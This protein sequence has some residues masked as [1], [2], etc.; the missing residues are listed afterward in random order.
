[1]SRFYSL[2][3]QL[4]PLTEW[5]P[6]LCPSYPFSLMKVSTKTALGNDCK[7]LHQLRAHNE[8]LQSMGLFGVG[9]P[10][11]KD[12]WESEFLLA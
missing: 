9:V 5:P 4:R 11:R 10:S 1:M 3:C 2:S 6:S 12:S 7:D 8:G